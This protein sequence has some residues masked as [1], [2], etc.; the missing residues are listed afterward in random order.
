[1]G[2]KDVSQDRK[3]FLNDSGS[4]VDIDVLE[5]MQKINNMLIDMQHELIREKQRADFATAAEAESRRQMEKAKVLAE[6]ANEAKS[7]FLSSM[8]HDLRTPLNGIIGFTEIALQEKDPEKVKKYLEKIRI[9]GKLLQDIVN[10]TLDISRIESGKMILKPESVKCRVLLDEVVMALKPLADAKK[11]SFSTDTGGWG[12]G[13]VRADRLK[14]QKIFMNLISNAIKYTP[15]GGKV[16]VRTKI[17]AGAEKGQIYRLTVK[18][19]GIGMSREFLSRLYEPFAQENRRES[20]GVTGTGLGMAIVKRITDA[21]QG[22]IEVESSIGKGTIF[23]VGIPMLPAAS[24]ERSLSAEDTDTDFSGRKALLCEDNQ[25]NAEISTFLLK[26]KGMEV[27]WAMDGEEGLRKFENSAEDSY[28]IILMDMQMPVM[29]GIEAAKKIR[30]LNRRDAEKTPIVALT[31]NAFEED[32]KS[33]LD[34][35]M[36]GHISKPVNSD[37]LYSVTAKLLK[38]SPA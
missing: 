34:A 32:M 36:N 24:T 16:W 15:K 27:D 19:N 29:G 17:T 31:G 22:T 28:D 13:N 26:N 8:S 4:P 1:M 33:C 35:G 9:S 3:L 23:E 7:A 18:D 5:S 12:N 14:L 20:E 25:I 10:D 38:G 11:I 2:K 21:M 37:R 6:Q 30:A